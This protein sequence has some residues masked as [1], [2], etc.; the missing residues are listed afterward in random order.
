VNNGLGSRHEEEF[1][2]QVRRY[3]YR[4]SNHSIS[5]NR[6]HRYHY[7]PT[8]STRN[9]YASEESRSIS[10]V[11]HVRHQRIRYKLDNLQGERYELDNLQGE[12]RKINPPTF[13]GETRKGDDVET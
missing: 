5:D 9:F 13:D 11:S 10:E 3:N 8:H 6:D 2:P 1:I 4:G 7:S 12:L